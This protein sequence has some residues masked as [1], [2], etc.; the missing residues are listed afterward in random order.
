MIELRVLG[1]AFL[2]RDGVAL[3]GRAAQRHHLALLATLAASPG[4][5]ATRDKLITHFWPES[6][7][8]KARHRLS[9]A[10]HVVRHDLGHETLITSGDG[11]SLNRD[12]VWT[13]VGCFTESVADGR[14]AE[15]VELYRGPFLDGFFLDGLPDFDPWVEAERG[16]L[17]GLYRVSLE[18]LIAEYEGRRDWAAAARWWQRLAS[19]DPF[20]APVALGVV[21]ALASMG[22]LAGAVRHAG[23]YA[24]LVEGEMELPADPNVIELA[25]ELTRRAQQRSD[26]AGAREDSLSSLGREPTDREPRVT[27]AV[28]PSGVSRRWAMVAAAAGIAFATLFGLL[29]LLG[30]VE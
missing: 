27:S 19:H 3:R 21:R 1:G 17:A 2:A 11:V 5:H 30:A 7:G 10:L 14:L 4:R 28:A 25:E 20:S 23:A 24:A 8:P 9:V 6:E 26:G 29:A 13:D 12:L 22:D 16:R 15:A 18:K